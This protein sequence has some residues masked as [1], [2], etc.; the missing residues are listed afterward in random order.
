MWLADG[1]VKL[2]ISKKKIGGGLIKLRM[3]TA[4]DHQLYLH[5]IHPRNNLHVH[6][7]HIHITV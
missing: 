7:R 5:V 3:H 6:T 4:Y 2:N 1:A